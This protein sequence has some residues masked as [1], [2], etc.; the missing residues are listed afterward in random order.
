MLKAIKMKVKKATSKE[1]SIQTRYHHIMGLSSLRKATARDATM[2]TR[3]TKKRCRPL[4][5]KSRRESKLTMK[6]MTRLK[7][8]E[9]STQLKSVMLRCKESYNKLLHSNTTI[10]RATVNRRKDTNK[11]RAASD[12]LTKRI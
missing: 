5:R 4:T 7:L 11:W 12:S 10:R 6:T 9:L 3:K 2:T 1:N 8:R